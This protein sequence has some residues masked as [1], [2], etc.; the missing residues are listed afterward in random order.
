MEKDEYPIKTMS[1]SELAQAYGIT[2]I[3]FMKWVKPFKEQIGYNDKDHYFTPKQV[4]R[5]FELLGSPE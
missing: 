1:K 5:V 3:T 2:R 4:A